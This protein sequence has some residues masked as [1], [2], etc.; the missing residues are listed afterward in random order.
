MPAAHGDGLLWERFFRV[1]GRGFAAY[2]LPGVAKN[3]RGGGYDYSVS[4][5]TF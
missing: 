2:L 1:Y 5:F 3:F 4:C